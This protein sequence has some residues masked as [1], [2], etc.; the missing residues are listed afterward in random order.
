MN[1]HNLSTKQED[2]LQFLLNRT[3]KKHHGKILDYTKEYVLDNEKDFKID[4]NW[5]VSSSQQDTLVEFG[6]KYCE[7]LY[8]IF[9]DVEPDG[10]DMCTPEQEEQILKEIEERFNFRELL[11]ECQNNNTS[12]PA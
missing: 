12:L 2:I 11:K 10:G 3:N 9:P 1:K 5:C 6:D 7:Q 4:E 8:V